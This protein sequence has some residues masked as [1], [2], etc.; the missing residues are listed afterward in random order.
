[1][2]RYIAITDI[3]GE[4]EKLKNLISKLD[5][6]GDETFVFMGD[7]I[8]RGPDS[9]GVIDY[10]IDF[11]TQHKCVYLIGSHEY[12][13]MNARKNTD[14]Y[15]NFLFWNYGGPETVKSYG[16]FDNIYKIHGEFF[17]SLKF[18]Y[19][20][21]KYLF[22]HAGINPDYS[23][24]N[25]SEVDLVYIRSAFYNKKNPLKQKIIFG[26]TDFQKPFIAED[27]IGIDL[28]CGKYKDAKL[29]GL[30]LDNESEE[31]VYSD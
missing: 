11:G 27:K 2:S 18:Y 17:E 30:I 16:N 19:L 22:V 8:D 3:H 6:R 9:R 5:I 1:M 26:H 7:Y 14:E 23:L 29:C 4:C 21:D 13:Y 28:G 10:L 15:Y 20:T 24:E 12:A 25:Q 31:F